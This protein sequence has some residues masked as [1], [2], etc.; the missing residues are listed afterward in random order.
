MLASIYDVGFEEGC[1]W[2]G[3]DLG[4]LLRELAI[5][6]AD[7]GTMDLEEDLA[8]DLHKRGRAFCSA[9]RIAQ[10]QDGEVMIS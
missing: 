9:I 2:R 5:L 8:G 4:R 1:Q 10:E 7:W 3:A 6:E